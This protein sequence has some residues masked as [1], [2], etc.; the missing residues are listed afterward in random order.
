MKQSI[1]KTPTPLLLAYRYSD[2]RDSVVGRNFSLEAEDGTLTLAIDLSPNFHA[3]RREASSYSDALNLVHNH[4]RLQL[5]QCGD[6]LLRVRLAKH[7]DRVQQ[8]EL[9]LRLELGGRGS[10][11]YRVAAHSL[12][13]GGVQLD[14]QE[15]LQT[16]AELAHGSAPPPGVHH[17]AGN[18]A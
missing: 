15:V 16:S 6:N 17:I 3:R 1:R 14:V 10:C 18:M 4:H 5:L 8:P 2:M 11:L 7:W 12:F 9:R 13:T